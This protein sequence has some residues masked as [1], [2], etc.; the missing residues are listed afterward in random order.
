[1][2][3]DA[4]RLRAG[5]RPIW[6]VPPPPK[7]G[8]PVRRFPTV[9]LGSTLDAGW[10]SERIPLET[11]PAVKKLFIMTL[12]YRVAGLVTDVYFL[13]VVFLPPFSL[14][15]LLALTEKSYGVKPDR[16]F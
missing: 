1:M 2:K 12:S 3:S 9:A 7:P 15:T 10:D 5:L 4:S 16:G 14:T 13:M 11:S 8:L 6:T